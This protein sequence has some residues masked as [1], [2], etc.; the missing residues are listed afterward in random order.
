[1]VKNKESKSFIDI[2]TIKDFTKANIVVITDKN[3][4]TLD[5]Y[6]TEY[7]SNLSLMS[8]AAFEMCNDLLMDITSSALTQLIAKCDENYYII[9]KTKNNN[10]VLIASD[11]TSKLGLLMKYMN[12]L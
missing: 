3:G 2:N 4:T 12:T 11:D 5:Y 9:N 6:Q 7:S 1:M 10:F 8:Q